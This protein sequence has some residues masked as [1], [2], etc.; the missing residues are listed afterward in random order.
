MIQNKKSLRTI[1]IVCDEIY[2]EMKRLTP[3]FVNLVLRQMH[4]KRNRFGALNLEE[5]EGVLEKLK[6]YK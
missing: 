3:G 6:T 2:Q 4:P 5:L 1:P